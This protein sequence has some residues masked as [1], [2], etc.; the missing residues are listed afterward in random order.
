MPILHQPR[1]RS[2]TNT[3]TRPRSETEWLM[4]PGEYG[5][6]QSEQLLDL[7]ARLV[8]DLDDVSRQCIEA[9]HFERRSFSQLADRLGVSKTHAWRLTKRAEMRMRK[10]LLDIT[11]IRE[12]YT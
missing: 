4:Q 11:D 5:K 2:L 7:V 10:A 9:I 6:P 8:D 1:Y 3:P 12:K